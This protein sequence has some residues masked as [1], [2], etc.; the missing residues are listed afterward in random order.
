MTQ[1]FKKEK[2]NCKGNRKF[3]ASSFSKYESIKKKKL[4]IERRV[5]TFVERQLIYKSWNKKA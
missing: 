4:Y 1:W 2:K 3:H 5:T